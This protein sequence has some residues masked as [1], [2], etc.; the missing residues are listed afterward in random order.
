M[1]KIASRTLPSSK[2]KT[3]E[4]RKE[5][6]LRMSEG[7]RKLTY[8]IHK[9]RFMRLKNP[10]CVICYKSGLL[11]IPKFR[12]DLCHIYQKFLAMSKRALVKQ[13]P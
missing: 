2:R 3:G 7:C 13:H 1:W 8:I 12:N 11:Y 10:R 9:H 6:R 4:S 5:C